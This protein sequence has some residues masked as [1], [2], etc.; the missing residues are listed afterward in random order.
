MSLDPKP[1]VLL[2]GGGGQVGQAF[3][4]LVAGTY[5][6]VAPSRAILDLC[7]PDMIAT[8]VEA[9]S[10]SLVINAGAYT[11]VDRAESEPIEA[12]RVNAVAPAALA[13]ATVK[14]GVP[15]I[16]ISTDYVFN[17]MKP[18]AYLESDP[19][20][21]ISVY[22]A[23]KEGGEQAVRTQNPRHVILRTAWV[24][25]PYG[26]NFIKTMLRLAQDRDQLAVVDDQLGC[27]TSAADIAGTL[28]A[29]ADRLMSSTDTPYGTYH[30]VNSGEATWC[31][32]AR[33]VFQRAV[34]YN[35]R[36]PDVRAIPSSD[37]PTPARRPMNS[38]LDTAKITQDFGV[39]PRSWHQ[40]VDQ[41]VDELLKTEA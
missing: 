11:A 36:V 38:R 34:R 35:Q 3:Q 41:V 28:V 7:E 29:V 21:P 37:Y 24:V 25:S 40:A 5:D 12:W 19:V 6:V 31:E 9:G 22:G 10:W 32:L 39:V 14:A 30:F 1:R 13:L 17:G 33:R 26:Q 4:R 15:L 2:T 23:S 20:G 18:S 27:P 16:Q 8:F